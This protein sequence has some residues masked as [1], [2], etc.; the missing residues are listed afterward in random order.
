M[1]EYKQAE[2]WTDGYTRINSRN[3]GI[4]IPVTLNKFV[5]NPNRQT[6]TLTYP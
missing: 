3:Y 1:D 2:G 4:Y 5:T 6:H